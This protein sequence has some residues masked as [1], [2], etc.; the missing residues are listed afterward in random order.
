VVPVS[1]PTQPTSSA[2]DVTM[3]QLRLGRQGQ[4]WFIPFVDECVGVQVRL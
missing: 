4:V 2:V 3:V 1:G